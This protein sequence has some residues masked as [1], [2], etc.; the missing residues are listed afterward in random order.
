MMLKPSRFPLKVQEK[1]SILRIRSELDDGSSTISYKI[2]EAETQKI[3][4]MV[5]CG[6]RE[7][8]SNKISIRKHRGRELGLLTVEKFAKVIRE[9]E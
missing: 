2:R 8:E 5:I 9:A 1:L 4:Y 3:R 7:A 6:K